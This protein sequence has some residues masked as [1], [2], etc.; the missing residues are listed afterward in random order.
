MPTV[1]DGSLPVIDVSTSGVP[2]L[3]V[4]SDGHIAWSDDLHR[5]A[6]SLQTATVEPVVVTRTIAAIRSNLLPG[7]CWIGETYTGPDA[8]VT[9]V[10]IREG[11][12]LIV[13]VAS[14]HERFESN[15]QLVVTA[16]GVEPLNGRSREEVLAQQPGDYQTFRRRWERMFEYLRQL[17]PPP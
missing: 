8:E 17:I 5:G 16:T 10:R 9:T 3:Q 14:W 13:D 15:P 7:G 11:D 12:T 4:W 6:S 1:P 2:R